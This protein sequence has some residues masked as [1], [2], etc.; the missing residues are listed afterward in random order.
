MK[1]GPAPPK[2]LEINPEPVRQADSVSAVVDAVLQNSNVVLRYQNAYEMMAD[3]ERE[4][5]YIRDQYEKAEREILAIIR[6]SLTKE[7]HQSPNR[8]LPLKNQTREY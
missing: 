1:P 8:I 6:S 5:Q 2:P 3:R 7:V 4:N